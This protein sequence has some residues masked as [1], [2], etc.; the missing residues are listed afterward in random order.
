MK[1]IMLCHFNHIGGCA[2]PQA[3]IHCGTCAWKRVAVIPASADLRKPFSTS[4]RRD[5]DL[6]NSE[7][8]LFATLNKKAA[9]FEAASD[10]VQR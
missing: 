10:R 8:L 4:Q 1:T 5:D 6:L 9:P 3:Y 2:V 7:Q